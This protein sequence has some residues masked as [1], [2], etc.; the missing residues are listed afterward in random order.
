MLQGQANRGLHPSCLLPCWEHLEQPLPSPGL[1][2][3]ET[4]EIVVCLWPLRALTC[5]TFVP[6]STPLL[7]SP[8]RLSAFLS[9]G[10]LNPAHLV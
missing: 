8:R 7:S 2:A 5:W 10:K 9:H 6:G 1:C 4:L 3:C